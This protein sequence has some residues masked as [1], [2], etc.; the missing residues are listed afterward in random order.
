[1]LT[2]GFRHPERATVVAIAVWH[3]ALLAFGHMKTMGAGLVTL[4]LA[5]IAQNVATIGI[6]AAILASAE[7]SLRGRALGAR[8]L[9]IY[10]LPLG[11]LIAGVL[12]DRMGFPWT[13]TVFAVVGLL[14]TGAIGFRWRDALWH[15]SRARH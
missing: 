13:N 10:G 4:F 6:V 11:L 12:I 5:G 14:M 8:T 9:A 7:P 3:A 15:R 1:V 2:P